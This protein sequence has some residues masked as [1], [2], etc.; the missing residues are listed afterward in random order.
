MN[1]AINIAFDPLVPWSAIAVLGATTLLLIGLSLRARAR[2]T[3]WRV[4][5]LGALLAALANPLLV[6]EER[7]FLPD[8]A[9]V[10]VDKSDSQS[11]GQRPQQLEAHDCSADADDGPVPVPP[12]CR[13]ARD[14]C[15]RIVGRRHRVIPPKRPAPQ[16]TS[17]SH[18]L[19]LR[20]SV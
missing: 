11:I 10:V 1:N 5:V 7:R 15:R 6:Q 2:G 16:L 19:G 9:L 18:A 3:L 12:L 13:V 8:I 14:R 20:I 4:V 17:A